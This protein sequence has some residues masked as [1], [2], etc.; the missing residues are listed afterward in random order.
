MLDRTFHRLQFSESM[1]ARRHRLELRN[2]SVERCKLE[3]NHH[4]SALPSSFEGSV[5]SL[6]FEFGVE[7][8]MTCRIH[9]KESKACSAARAFWSKCADDHIPRV[10]CLARKTFKVCRHLRESAT[11]HV[12]VDLT[13]ESAVER[14]HA[15]FG[16]VLI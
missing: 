1:V 5:M 12:R 7:P 3:S 9:A 13:C 16:N 11:C 8:R 10:T 4:T 15:N 2:E 14:G 6:G